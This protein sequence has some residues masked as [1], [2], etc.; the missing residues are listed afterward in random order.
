MSLERALELAAGVRVAGL[1]AGLDAALVDRARGVGQA[2]LDRV[3]A[4]VEVGG[5]VRRVMLHQVREHGL[6]LREH[7]GVLV[8]E[9]EAVLRERIVGALLDERL[10]QLDA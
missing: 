1:G 3:V 6:G 8:L 9:R 5:R 4:R 7:A 2:Q 10:Q